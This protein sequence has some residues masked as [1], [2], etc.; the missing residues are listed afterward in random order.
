[1]SS[2]VQYR[3]TTVDSSKIENR[4]FFQKTSA[5][6]APIGHFGYLGVGGCRG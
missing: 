2:T 1:M 6:F 4:D 3:F 5:D